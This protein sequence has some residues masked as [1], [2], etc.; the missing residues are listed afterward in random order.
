[1]KKPGARPQKKSPPP[2]APISSSE[3]ARK[4]LLLPL[5][6]VGF[7]IALIAWALWPVTK[8]ASVPLVD[9]TAVAPKIEPYQMQAQAEAQAHAPVSC[10]TIRPS[11]SWSEPRRGLPDAAS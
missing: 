2:E 9:P 4:S 6:I 10:T 11:M 8:S 3:T 5:G 1:M 7:I